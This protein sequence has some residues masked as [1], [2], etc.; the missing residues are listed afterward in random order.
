[1][2]Y[3]DSCYLAKLYLHET[4]S[5]EVRAAVRVASVAVCSVHGMVEVQSVFHR[6]LREGWVSRR[7]FDALMEQFALEAPT[8][9]FRWLPLNHRVIGVAQVMI[10]ALPATVFLRAADALHLAT[11]KQTGFSEIYT[12]DRHLLAAAPHFGLTGVCL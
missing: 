12:S 3:V 4:N 6:K 8:A 9:K 11:A 2:I 10:S 5:P 7:Q 1:M